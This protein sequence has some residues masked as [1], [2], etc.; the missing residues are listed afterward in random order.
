MRRTTRIAALSAAVFTVAAGVT[1]TTASAAPQAQWTVSNP[2]AN[3]T[4]TA[5]NQSGVNA[6]LTNVTTGATVTCAV[7][8]A[9]GTA[10]DGTY[11]S[12]AGLATIA[13]A[14]FGT[15]A[16]KCNG[17]LGSKWVSSA[18]QPMKLN[19]VSY[20]G[21]VTKGTLTNVKVNLTG[22]SILGTCN[23]VIEG[24]A[25]TGT[26]TNSSGLLAIAADATPALTVTSASGACAGL[27]ATGN[28]AKFSATYKVT[29]IITVTSP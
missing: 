27:I 21:G 29:P 20:G 10:V 17:P 19:G 9:T 24:S 5:A 11:A 25:N 22:T 3:D 18:A 13:T 26:Y 8:G 23:A 14:T 4:F 28:K 1:V 12:G 7:Y 15:S 2:A 6:V 16:N